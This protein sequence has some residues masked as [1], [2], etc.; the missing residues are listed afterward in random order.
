MLYAAW[1]SPCLTEAL[2]A[3]TIEAM[4]YTDMSREELIAKCEELSLLA[5]QLV[6]EKQQEARLDFDWTGN[7]GHW[8]WNIKTNSVTFN[9]LKVTTLGYEL[10]ADGSAVPYQFFTGTRCLWRF[11]KSFARTPAAATS[12]A[13]MVGKNSS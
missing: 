6:R 1:Q 8:Y 7:L 12:P 4:D 5:D 13:V 3:A 11:P 2:Y 9:P 10:P